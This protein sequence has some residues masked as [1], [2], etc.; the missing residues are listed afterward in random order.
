[1]ITEVVVQ[2]KVKL[3]GKKMKVKVI[4]L[5]SII[6]DN[7]LTMVAKLEMAIISYFYQLQCRQY[8]HATI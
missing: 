5:L 7:V 6:D 2:T 8:V 1:M 3:L 4:P